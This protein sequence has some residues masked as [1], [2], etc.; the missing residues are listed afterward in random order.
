MKF[1]NKKIIEDRVRQFISWLET[2]QQIKIDNILYKLGI[3][4]DDQKVKHRRAASAM[5][6]HNSSKCSNIISS[7]LRSSGCFNNS[8]S[9]SHTWNNSSK[10]L[11][12][13]LFTPVCSS[14][15]LPPTP[16]RGWGT[17]RRC[18]H[19]PQPQLNKKKCY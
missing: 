5:Y 8:N 10:R 14:M 17:C 15:Y 13:R 11:T 19:L 16:T 6:P 4:E 7:F 9:S 3:G 2:H 1:K 12:K 18:L